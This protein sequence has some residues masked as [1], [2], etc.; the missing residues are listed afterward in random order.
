[1]ADALISPGLGARF[2][3][4][5]APN[6]SR[7]VQLLCGLGVACFCFKRLRYWR[8]RR[9]GVGIPHVQL[10]QRELYPRLIDLTEHPEDANY[11]SLPG[12]LVRH[13]PLSACEKYILE[14]PASAS[15]C[16]IPRLANIPLPDDKTGFQSWEFTLHELLELAKSGSPLPPWV[17]GDFV[18]RTSQALATGLDYL[19]HCGWAHLNVCPRALVLYRDGGARLAGLGTAVPLESTKDGVERDNRARDVVVDLL[20]DLAER[21]ALHERGRGERLP[22]LNGNTIWPATD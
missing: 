9:L 22:A 12:L 21:Y 17:N 11:G 19:H 15:T 18:W 2:L 20:Q 13:L 1:M 7:V 8:P 4:I 10:A 16:L 5:A 3:R 6:W 14:T